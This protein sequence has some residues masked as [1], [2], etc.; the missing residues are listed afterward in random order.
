MRGPG[1]PDRLALSPKD[2]RKSAL[3]VLKEVDRK[4]VSSMLPILRSSGM[5]TDDAERMF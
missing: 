2:V 5:L 4:S 1:D 3:E